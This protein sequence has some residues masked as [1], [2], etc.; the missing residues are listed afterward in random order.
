MRFIFRFF[1]VLLITASAFSNAYEVGFDKTNVPPSI[2]SNGFPMALFYPTSSEPKVVELG[3]FKLNVAVEG[4]VLKGKH[5]LVIV[6]HGSGGSHLSYKDVAI[7]LAKNGFIVGMPLHPQNNYMDNSLE[8]SV[9]NYTNRPKHITL[10]IDTLLNASDLNTYIDSD[11]IAVLGHSVGGYA[12][13]AAAGGVGDTSSLIKICRN[14]PLLTDPYCTPVRDGSMTKTVIKSKKD[15]RIK[16]VIIMA[17]VGVLFSTEGSL[18]DVDIPVLLLK[19]EK[20][21]EVTEPYNADIIEKG[22]PNKQQLI[23]IMIPDAGHYSFLTS[24]PDF[25][26]P[27]LGLIAEDPDGFNRAEFQEKLGT[28]IVDYLKGVLK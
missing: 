15:S 28:I 10:A 14:S 7:S 19:A 6:S 16:A 25:L 1:V 9:T 27:E 8:G 13:I 5:P 26:K 24:F 23:S 17:P 18:N 3:P 4:E 12:A 21:K 22:L 11:K 2:E 20:D